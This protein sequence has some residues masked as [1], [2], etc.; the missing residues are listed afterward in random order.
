M[1]KLY[2]KNESAF[3]IVWIVA[4]VVV[5]GSLQA[6]FGS[7]SWAGLVA[8]AAFTLLSLAF[9]RATNTWKKYGLTGL[10]PAKPY[11][12]FI[13]LL[14]VASVN[15]WLGIAPQA[16]GASLVC[17]VASMA[18]VGWLEEIIF[19]GF[20]FRAM[21]KDGL[22][23]AIVVSALTFGMGH[24][25]NLLMGHATFG[26]LLQVCY[27]TAIGFAFVMVFHKGGSLWPCIAAHS[28][29]DVTGST[30]LRP[31]SSSWW[32]GATPGTSAACQSRAHDLW[33]V[34][35]PLGFTIVTSS[36]PSAEEPAC[37]TCQLSPSSAASAP[38][39]A[40]S[41]PLREAAGS[42]RCQPT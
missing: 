25:V 33:S 13:P 31:S 12:F 3:A 22:T 30:S 39:P 35:S 26:T 1:L 28:L 41:T 17:A 24:I 10:P 32:P 42:S 36:V 15:L 9:L 40:S 18:L 29:I 21:E 38:P 37:P 23:S 7:N 19:R 16:T 4:Y 14:L 27:A 5:I 8:L 11:L 6:N 2:E 20:L 34:G